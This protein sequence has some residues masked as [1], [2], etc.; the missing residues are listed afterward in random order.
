[1]HSLLLVLLGGGALG[2]LLSFGGAWILS[3]RALVP[4]EAAFRRQ[5]EFVADASHELR[6]P[7]TVLRSATVCSTSGATNRSTPMASSSTTRAEIAHR[8]TGGRP[9]LRWLARTR[10]SWS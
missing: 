4:I 2:L 8:A 3:G 10:A 5:Q 1:M 6:T 7:L 9:A